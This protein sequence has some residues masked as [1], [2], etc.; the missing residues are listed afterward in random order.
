MPFG[1]VPIVLIDDFVRGKA[2]RDCCVACE[3]SVTSCRY[4]SELIFWL[5]L[6]DIA[7]KVVSSFMFLLREQKVFE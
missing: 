2:A 3:S 6:S 5:L 4:S 7:G 1:M